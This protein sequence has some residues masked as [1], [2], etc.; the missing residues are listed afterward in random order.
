MKLYLCIV[1]LYGVE[2]MRVVDSSQP[3][4][5]CALYLYLTI[6]NGIIG[7]SR[8]HI[9]GKDSTCFENPHYYYGSGGVGATHGPGRGDNWLED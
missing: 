8:L 9:W 1:P 7:Q 5:M 2:G 4:K 6:D 3:E